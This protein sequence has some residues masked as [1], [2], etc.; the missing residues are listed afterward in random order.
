M[1]RE[2]LLLPDR[3]G[4]EPQYLET[5]GHRLYSILGQKIQS[6]IDSAVAEAKR[7]R[8]FLLMRLR[9]SADDPKYLRLTD[10]PWSLL[11]NDYGFLAHQGV[12]F[13]RYIAYGSPPPN[14]P[15]V[16]RLQVLLI[17]SAAGDERM[18]LAPLPSTEREAVAAGLQQ[19]QTQ[20]KIQLDCLTPPTLNALRGKTATVPHV[21]HF[22]GHGFFG[23]RC[24]QVGCGKA[25]KQGATRCECDAPLGEPQGYLV[26]EDAEG[27]ADYVSAKE[28]RELLGN[29]QRREQANGEPGIVVVVLSSCRSG[30]SRRSQSVF[31]GVA[32]S[33]IFA[34]VPA[35]VAMTYSIRVDA[36]S[37]F[38]EW[39]YRAIGE[40]EP[41]AIALRRGQSAMG[42]EG[43]QWYRP[44]LYLRWRDNQGGQVFQAAAVDANPLSENHSQSE[45]VDKPKIRPKVSR[46]TQRKI[47]SLEQYLAKL[48][49][50]YI[51][52]DEKK[53]R[54]SNP[55]ER[56]NLELQLESIMKQIKNIEQ[57]LNQ[58]DDGD[59]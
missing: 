53:R 16:D 10:Y 28:L 40:Q 51:D 56:N 26:F 14:L 13:S 38:A 55:Q 4:F 8:T 20:G 5:I 25:Y 22:D 19:A 59:E 18:G 41:L 58:L 57:E 30:M 39:F 6:V 15:P 32:Q 42:I 44:V 45:K 9:F 37:T 21:L 3:T 1:V 27:K 49:K 17:S 29:L 50:D 47:E 34:G 43:N 48:E 36:A 11:C 52:V 35:V 46:A 24:N 31:N 54:E 33:L 23:K 12:T 2:Q 7:D